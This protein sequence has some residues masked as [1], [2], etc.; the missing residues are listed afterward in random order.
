MSP[1]GLA[2]GPNGTIVS[3]TYDVDRDSLGLRTEVTLRRHTA[4]GLDDA[5]FGVAGAVT[6]KASQSVGMVRVAGGL[7]VFGNEG[8]Q[9]YVKRF[10]E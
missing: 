3:A 9:I 4:S 5:T 1:R 2:L 8:D 6:T 7:L 10:A